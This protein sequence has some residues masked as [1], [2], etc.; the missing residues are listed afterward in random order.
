MPKTKWIVA[1]A[2]LAVVKGK[3]LT[4]K[5]KGKTSKR[6]KQIISDNSFDSGDVSFCSSSGKEHSRSDES[7]S[8]SN[9]SSNGSRVAACS[10]GG[11]RSDGS[12]TSDSSSSY[13]CGTYHRRESLSQSSS[14]SL[15]SDE[16]SFSSRFGSDSSTLAESHSTSRSLM[17]PETKEFHSSSF[18][19]G[20]DHAPKNCKSHLEEEVPNNPTSETLSEMGV[21]SR[22]TLKSLVKAM[23]SKKLIK[24]DVDV[25]DV[26]VDE[27]SEASSKVSRKSNLSCVNTKH[28]VS[29]NPPMYDDDQAS[30]MQR[31]RS[32]KGGGRGR[33][34]NRGSQGRGGSARELKN[35]G[36]AADRGSV[37]PFLVS[38]KNA[39][40]PLNVEEKFSDL[41]QRVRRQNVVNDDDFLGR[42]VEVQS[43]ASLLRVGSQDSVVKSEFSRSGLARKLA[44]VHSNKLQA[45]SDTNAE[46]GTTEAATVSCDAGGELSYSLKT[47]LLANANS[48][49]RSSVTSIASVESVHSR[50]DDASRKNVGSSRFASMM[51]NLKSSNETNLNN[52]EFKPS[53]RSIRDDDAESDD[54]LIFE[55]PKIVNEKGQSMRSLSSNDVCSASVDEEEEEG[56]RSRFRVRRP[57]LRQPVHGKSGK[58]LE[59]SQDK[60]KDGT[61][62]KQCDSTIE[63]LGDYQNDDD[64]KHSDASISTAS[65]G[66]DQSAI[67]VT[68]LARMRYPEDEGNLSDDDLDYYGEPAMTILTP[69]TEMGSMESDV[70]TTSHVSDAS[71]TDSDHDIAKSPR[72][73]DPLELNSVT[74]KDNLS[75]GRVNPSKRTGG[76]PINIFQVIKSVRAND[77][78]F[79][80]IKLDDCGLKDSDAAKLL[81]LLHKNSYVTHVS[82]SNNNLGNDSAVSLAQ[83][84]IG[85][86]TIAFVCLRGNNIGN[87]G[88]MALKRVSE[89]ND[90]LIHLDI[91]DNEVDS[92]VMEGLQKNSADIQSDFLSSTHVEQSTMAVECK[93]VEGL[94]LADSDKIRFSE[95]GQSASATVLDK[96]SITFSQKIHLP[97]GAYAAGSGKGGSFQR[98]PIFALRPEP[99]TFSSASKNE[100]TLNSLMKIFDKISIPTNKETQASQGTSFSAGKSDMKIRGET[101]LLFA[102]SLSLSSLDSDWL[103]KTSSGGAEGRPPTTHHT[104]GERERLKIENYYAAEAELSFR[105]ASRS[106]QKMTS[107]KKEDSMSKASSLRNSLLCLSEQNINEEIDVSTDSKNASSR[108]L[109]IN[110]HALIKPSLSQSIKNLQL[111]ASSFKK[112]DPRW[113][114]R[115]FFNDM[116]VFGTVLSDVTQSDHLSEGA[117][118]F[119]VWRPTSA[120]AIAKMMRGD[121]VG[122][123]L[124]IKGKSAKKGDLS[125]YIPFLQIHQEE[126]KNQI[127]TIPK[128]DRT[129][130]FFKRHDVRDRVGEYLGKVAKELTL[131]VAHAKFALARAK[132][133][134]D[135]N[136]IL[137]EELNYAAKTLS[138]E[139]ENPKV[140]QNDDYAPEMY[141]IEISCRVLWEG[142]VERKDITRNPESKFDTG[143]ASQ[144]A[145]Q[146]MNFA[147]L[148]RRNPNEPLPVLYQCSEDDPF[149]ARML[150]MA[151]EEEGKV[152]PVVSDFDC[153][154]IGSRNFS[155]ED[156]MSPE[157]VELLDW[158]VS[159][160]EWIL[161]N[162][163]GPESWTT[164]WLEVL[165]YAARNGFYPSMPRF[166]FGDPTSYS[167]IEASVHRSAKTCGAVR[168]GPECFNFFFPQELDDEFLIIFPGS[169]IW[170]YV[171]EKEL[172][173]I[174]R[175]K[176]QEGYTFPLNPKWLLCDPGWISLFH[177]LLNS[178]QSSVQASIDLWFPPESGLRER[179][180][181]INLRFPNGFL[182]GD[183]VQGSPSIAEEEYERYLILQRARRKIRGFIYWRNL[184]LDVRQRASS[185]VDDNCRGTVEEFQFLCNRRKRQLSAKTC[186]IEDET[187]KEI[188]KLDFFGRND[189]GL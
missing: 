17:L 139:L 52:V 76:S 97:G 13:G 35:E 24:R 188:R 23:S 65:S 68:N 5:K 99:F 28:N 152:V 92:Y 140:V 109:S 32:S 115:K 4:N 96:R 38:D 25:D 33:S 117:A 90:T 49:L 131:R 146:D 71:E 184:L 136:G 105:K 159:Q 151:Y 93:S 66:E 110:Q 47:E 164:R 130:I 178:N 74:R 137:R 181:D 163:T 78:N 60:P 183:Q 53:I 177:D 145:F 80:E 135:P 48:N 50:N 88:A 22:T 160:I 8:Y 46:A 12:E 44:Q 174:L 169:Q 179:I 180:L 106:L 6:D 185:S 61:D 114:I 119:S 63:R 41:L 79:K 157:Q 111:W 30:M 2:A 187:I 3:R 148:R 27:D 165:K 122:K 133:G 89:V 95:N 141:C 128:E 62:E 18:T 150:V 170:K 138:Y 20:A 37:R 77:P 67:P 120:D 9:Q 84:L 132:F 40:T 39:R 161:D 16:S 100:E 103:L 155:Y 166:G 168:H 19:V 56:K 98:P 51:A 81:C 108:P 126:H 58:S 153:F 167:M 14:S 91:N 118:I 104:L 149:D 112:L 142:L 45:Y 34:R 10:G 127:R 26:D 86:E 43:N 147:A 154:L 83:V 176:I 7:D 144:P 82:L 11:R 64:S 171:N 54:E 85:S 55:A 124:E 70:D 189:N 182:R 102:I 1:T 101:A 173:S 21:G 94:G 129:K 156:P 121:G 113:Q 87:K 72:T 116:S 29:L 31:R 59:I 15:H 162:H 134:C 186:D 75:K 125:G 36:L 69:I 42:D 175:E 107:S 123:G 57:S 172:L 143:R 73:V 158:C